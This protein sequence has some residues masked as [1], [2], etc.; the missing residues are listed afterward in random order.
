MSAEWVDKADNPGMAEL[1]LLSADIYGAVAIINFADMAWRIALTADFTV[2][3]PVVHTGQLT[4][5]GWLPQDIWPV[6]P[7]GRHQLRMPDLQARILRRF[8]ALKRSC[9]LAA[10]L[11]TR[12]VGVDLTPA[13]DVVNR[14]IP[15]Q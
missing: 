13:Q 11:R 15:S 14:Q 4:D 7:L 9:L 10:H 2:L 12:L 6:W 5:L 3:S 1:G 8:R